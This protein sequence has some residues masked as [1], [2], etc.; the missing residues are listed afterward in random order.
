ME[1]DTI[2]IMEKFI[3][4]QVEKRRYE[5]FKNRLLEDMLQVVMDKVR[6]EVLSK[7]SVTDRPKKK[8]D[9]MSEL[10]THLKTEIIFLREE[11]K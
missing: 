7:N 1:G 10:V 4:E 2:E 6:S 11:T 9:E 3:D 8:L 5:D